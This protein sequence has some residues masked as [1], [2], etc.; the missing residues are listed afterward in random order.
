MENLPEKP[1]SDPKDTKK[2]FGVLMLETGFEFLF[3]IG[4]PLIGFILLGRW[5]DNK[6]NH[7]FFVLVGILLAIPLSGYMVYK[8]AN[9]YRKF[10][11]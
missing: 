11:K 9:E 8:R 4:V 6:F 10:L 5:L 1:Q 3:L 7:H 2:L